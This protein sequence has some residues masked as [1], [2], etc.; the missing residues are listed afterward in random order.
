MPSPPSP[1]NPAE[2]PRWYRD[3]LRFDCTACGNCCRDHGEYTY[4][5][6]SDADLTALATRLELPEARVEQLYCQFEDGWRHLKR[7]KAAC[8]FL[9][10]KG[11]CSVYEGRPKQCRTWP[12][13]Q[14]TLA[15]KADWSG[16]V[17]ACCPGI[18]QGELTSAD[19][20]ERIAKE[21]EDWYEDS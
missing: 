13:W 21:T 10:D 8:T 20:A 12:F 7:E 2:D 18:D 16:P 1:A 3:G 11:L 5:Y 19:D 17:K 6:V 15:S 14:D 9:D 4:V